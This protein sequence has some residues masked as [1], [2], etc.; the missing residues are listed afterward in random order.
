MKVLL[1]N[2][3][4]AYNYLRFSSATSESQSQRFFE[5][6]LHCARFQHMVRQQHFAQ[7]LIDC[8]L[9]QQLAHWD[10][11]LLVR[12]QVQVAGDAPR[13]SVDVVTDLT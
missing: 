8:Q 2:Q 7:A 5:H 10:Q 13:N 9:S 12:H 3:N 4:H 11:R 6:G 1:C